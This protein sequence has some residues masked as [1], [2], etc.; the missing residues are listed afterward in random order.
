MSE[1]RDCGLGYCLQRDFYSSFDQQILGVVLPKTSG[2]AECTLPASDEETG[3]LL[4]PE[5]SDPVRLYDRSDAQ[6][7]MLGA[8]GD[9]RRWEWGLRCC[10]VV[11]AIELGE[12]IVRTVVLCLELVQMW[13]SQRRWQKAGWFRLRRL[14]SLRWNRWALQPPQTITQDQ[15]YFGKHEISELV[16][17]DLRRE[18]LGTCLTRVYSCRIP[19]ETVNQV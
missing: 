7:Q 13:T 4:H 17:P 2:A 10:E 3:S 18:R 12:E 14:K 15:C 5:E 8:D 11:N 6:R 1:R 19:E 16:G 9:L